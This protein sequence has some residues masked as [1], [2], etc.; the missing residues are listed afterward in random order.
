MPRF[1]GLLAIDVNQPCH[2]QALSPVAAF[3]EAA[4]G[5]QVVEP[6]LGNLGWV[7][8][9]LQTEQTGQGLFDA[10]RV[11]PQVTQ[12]LGLLALL[13]LPS[14]LLEEARAAARAFP[15][16]VPRGYLAR[17]EKGKP[18]DPL[19][20]QVLPLGAE[21]ETVAG[22]GSDPVGDGLFPAEAR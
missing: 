8:H 11:Q 15:L 10:R 21:L 6:E 18:D 16:R 1:V 9:C 3:G 5:Q 12:D 20:R 19:L 4:L 13:G 17:M 14:G 2:D 7:G 22:F